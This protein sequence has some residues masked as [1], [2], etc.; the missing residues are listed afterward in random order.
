M[1]FFEVLVTATADNSIASDNQ[2]VYNKKDNVSISR[3][4]RG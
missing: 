3:T 1:D 2:M 4:L